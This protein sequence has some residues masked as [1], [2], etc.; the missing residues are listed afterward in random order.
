MQ[1]L[2]EITHAIAVGVVSGSGVNWVS[3]WIEFSGSTI[4]NPEA[5]IG[6]DAGSLTTLSPITDII[7]A[8]VV[9][10]QTQVKF[11]SINTGS[12]S[13]ID[14]Y[15]DQITGNIEFS[16]NLLAGDTLFYVDSRGWFVLDSN[17]NLKVIDSGQA[18]LQHTT[19]VLLSGS[20]NGR[21]IAVAATATPGTLIHTAIASTIIFD[22]IWAW[23]TNRSGA[24]ATLTLEFGGTANSDHLTETLSIPANS[25]PIA[26]VQ[27]QVLNNSLNFR[28][29]SGTANA[30]NISG[31]VNRI[32]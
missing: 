17:G 19:K 24:A 29:F 12:N 27:G 31:F 21:P 1:A 23:V 16:I 9:G 10:N 5:N 32:S 14:I 30:L 3:S 6:S 11:I 7:P 13:T 15:Y 20:T 25:P 4:E 8:P 18:S 26:I 22:E 28:A 2:T